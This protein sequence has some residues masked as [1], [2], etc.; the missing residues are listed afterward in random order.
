M[1]DP[2]I[3]TPPF[4]RQ[5]SSPDSATASETPGR[6]PTVRMRRNRSGDGVRRLVAENKLSVDD[7][8]WTSFVVD[9]ENQSVPVES[10]PGVVRYSPDVM[11]E[12]A[13]SAITS[14]E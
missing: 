10:M 9:G 2:K 5:K 1:S 14:G 11:A 8:I 6:Y 7:L 3:V 12:A 13:A 4:G